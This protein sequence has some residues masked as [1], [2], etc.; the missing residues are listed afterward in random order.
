MAI[1]FVNSRYASSGLHQFSTCCKERVG[2]KKYCKEC[3]KDLNGSEILKGLDKETILTEAQSDKLKSFME[4][5][6]ME[7]IS[8]KDNLE[9]DTLIPFIL[10]TQIVFPSISKGFRKTDIKTFFSFK[11]AL[12]EEN[13][14]C[15]VKLIQRATEHL[16]LLKSQNGDLIFMELPFKHY[17]NIDEINRIKEGV[18]NTLE[19]EKINNP[20]EFKEQAR[21]FINNF[22]T[23][24]ELNEV[25]EKKMILMKKFVSDV[26]EGVVTNELQ[27]DIINEE[28]NPFV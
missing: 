6:I 19:I 21:G 4:S 8:V 1:N 23:E 7:V 18:S 3:G 27:E 17:H 5:G 2:H 11:E 22:D 28:V 12:E 20:T 15:I 25:E 26:R 16:G 9:M 14:V 10:K 24:K 13:K